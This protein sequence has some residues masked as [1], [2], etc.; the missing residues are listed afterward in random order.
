MSAQHM[1]TIYKGVRS[2]SGQTLIPIPKAVGLFAICY[3]VVIG[4]STRGKPDV[5]S[6]DRSYYTILYYTILYYTILYYTILYYTILGYIL[7]LRFLRQTLSGA[8]SPDNARVITIVAVIVAS[9]STSNSNRT[10]W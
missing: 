6:G 7:Y 1:N 3:C 2:A 4:S 10:L 5:G 8:S 9:S